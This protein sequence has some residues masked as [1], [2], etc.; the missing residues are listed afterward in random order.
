[1]LL[2]INKIRIDCGTQART[3]I[4]EDRVTHYQELMAEGVV[5]PPLTVH[6]D[7]VEYYLSD[8]FHRYHALNRN[9]K[10]QVEVRDIKG[11]LRDAVLYSKT[12]NGMH[13]EPM[14]NEDKRKIVVEML[15]DAEW[16]KWSDREIANQC[17]VSQPFVSKLRKE[18]G[19][20]PE[21]IKYK[22]S[23]GE[24]L[25]R[26]RVAEPK[27]EKPVALE[28]PK[29]EFQPDNHDPKDEVISELIR[30][31]DDLTMQ[32]AIGTAD[33][34]DLAKE[35]IQELREEVDSLKRELRAVTISRDTYQSENNQLRKQCT[36]YQ[37]KLKA[38]GL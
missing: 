10:K 27:E 5:F 1:M 35:T 6:F 33:N 37:K 2:D 8:G 28:T 13:G 22:H 38:A 25:E 11:T 30:Q 7:G 23:S 36:M 9:K 31:N 4:K 3:K 15:Q 29:E 26:Q 14:S 12:A 32:L 19:T 18:S 17:H 34:P 20:A 21:K 24:V 16:S